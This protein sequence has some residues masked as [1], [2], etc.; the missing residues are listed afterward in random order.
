[1]AVLAAAYWA[2]ALPGVTFWDSGEFIAAVAS[3]GIPH[4]PATPLYITIGRA[5]VVLL[6]AVPVARAATLLSGFA[7]ALAA[8]ALALFVAR[9]TKDAV[10]AFAAALCAGGMSTVWSS[11]T[12]TEAYATALLLATAML[13]AAE[14]AGR[15]GDARWV[16]LTAYAMAL[17][18]PM[19]LSALVAAPAAIVLA[20]R[21]NGGGWRWETM[22][23]LGGVFVL[24]IGMGRAS[25]PIVTAG[26]VLG[27]GVVLRSRSWRTALSV[28]IA[29][30]ACLILMLRAR[31]DPALN[32]N[33]PRTLQAV[34]DVIGRRQFGSFALWPRNAPVWLQLVNFFEYAD[35]QVALSL[36]PR[37]APAVARTAITLLFIA[38]GVFG[39]VTHRRLDRRSWLAFLV[40]FVGAS[41]GL[42][43]YLNFY[44]G[45]SLGYG[46]LPADVR[47]E[48][49]ERDYFF[50]LAFWTWGAWAGIGAVALARRFAPRA[51]MVG[52]AVAAL[53]LAL[54]WSAMDRARSVERDAAHTVSRAM[55]WGAPRNAVLLT[56]ADDDTF[57]SW[58][59]Q[60][61]EH[62]RPDVAVLLWGFL[63]QDWYRAQTARRYAIVIADST[64][65][66]RSLD[67]NARG[68]GRPLA[69]TV[70][71]DSSTRAMAGGEWMLRGLTFVRADSSAVRV[72]PGMPLVDTLAAREFVH[73]FGEPA[74][75]P[76]GAIDGTART[77]M[78]IVGC[79]A[80]YLK[81]ARK[82]IPADSLD[83]RCKFR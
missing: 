64:Q 18:V 10:M 43:A 19:H 83:S 75:P 54:N 40:L 4:P 81:A 5:W 63:Y 17:A 66:L 29:L 52:V 33:D 67:V 58:Y 62:E 72:G 42:V 49:R 16:A 31:H 13:L 22:A 7:T 47:H 2:T 41:I 46:I 14:R 55:L 24:A 57:L 9:V 34:W 60:I 28:V 45:Y 59:A 38:L 76:D 35:W 79:P 48:V 50:A 27:L 74:L 71:A 26:L 44:P 15:D 56:S 37:A 1:M 20:G 78:A 53:P 65:P 69:F 12:E 36:A 77:W 61:A 25:G 80:G 70:V 51:A 32:E 39:S 68:G 30:S 21:Q 11:A 23:L 6:G 8:G 73:E 3:W 82:A